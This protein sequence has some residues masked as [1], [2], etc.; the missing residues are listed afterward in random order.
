M[1]FGK[2]EVVCTLTVSQIERWHLVMDREGACTISVNNIER[3][4][5]VR[6]REGHVEGY[7]GET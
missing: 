6:R 7:R 1:A 2:G 5:L 3:R 4:H